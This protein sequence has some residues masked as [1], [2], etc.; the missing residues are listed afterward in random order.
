MN[1]L[2]VTSFAKNTQKV[3][4]KLNDVQEL[5]S[6]KTKNI[7]D[8][9]NTLFFANKLGLL[10]SKL[11]VKY[12]KDIADANVS[13]VCKNDIKFSVLS[14]TSR[15][16]EI[17]VI[18]ISAVVFYSKDDLS[19]GYNEITSI[20]AI[21]SIATLANNLLNNS[22]SFCSSLISYHNAKPI[23]KKIENLNLQ[24]E[25]G[26]VFE[27]KYLNF[28]LENL[29]YE[30]GDKKILK[31]FNWKILKNHKY[32]LVGPSGCGKSTLAK[33]ICGI[34]KPTNGNVYLNDEK[35]E[36]YKI[37]SILKN[38]GYIEANP[39]ILTDTV[40]N[41]ITLCD[42]NFDNQKYEKIIKLLKLES[43]NSDLIIDEIQNDL[44]VGQKQRI[45]FA[46]YLYSN[47]KYFILDEATSNLDKE[48][49]DLIL[50]YLFDKKDVTL[51]NISHHITNDSY[52]KYH[53]VINLS[54]S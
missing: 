6:S 32:A 37:K 35:I 25:V 30:I 48:T 50:N 14:F 12:N 31:N 2:L 9:I 36:K 28:N 20:G 40:K 54:N 49:S 44:S 17:L 5:Y 4:K 34:L 18:I 26:K 42:K 29:S 53:E 33:I 41:N 7:L 15:L 10:T 38:V 24:E 19:I 16:L 27:S 39:F 43:I 8:G 13:K 23:L 45:N 22:S 47:Y 1:F 52:K 3:G 21:L 46:R 51:I 11:L